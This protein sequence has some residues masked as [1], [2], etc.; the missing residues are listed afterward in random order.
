V[1]TDIPQVPVAAA[2]VTIVDVFAKQIE[3][4]GQLAVIHE[5][6]KAIPDHEQ[7]IRVLE[8]ARNRLIGTCLALSAITGGGA[9]WVALALAHR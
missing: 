7:R 2:P 4:G 5:Q 1:S 3:M 8:A 9:A 6:L